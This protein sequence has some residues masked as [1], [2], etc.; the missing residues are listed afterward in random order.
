MSIFSALAPDAVDERTLATIADLAAGDARLAI[1]LLRRAAKEAEAE[2]QDYL[3]PGL[4]AAV[5][6]SAT[7]EVHERNIALLSTHQRLLYEI[8]AKAGTVGAKEL[9]LTYEAEASRPE[10]PATR[11]RYLDSLER[12]GLIKQRGSTRGTRYCIADSALRITQ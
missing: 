2:G 5:S 11:R 3:S 6:D 8:I 12:Y 9:R 7:A 1:A 4:V 10:S